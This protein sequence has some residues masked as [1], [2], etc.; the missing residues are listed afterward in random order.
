MFNSNGLITPP[1]GRSGFGGVKD[2]IFHD[3][4]LEPLSDEFPSGNV[5]EGF[6]E[7]VVVDV[8]KGP[9]DVR[10][11]HPLLPP[12]RAGQQVDFLDGIVAAAPGRNP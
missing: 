5:T 9:L 11:D 4:G 12:V 3:P 6:Q 10:I 2:T 1:C 7:E 8:V